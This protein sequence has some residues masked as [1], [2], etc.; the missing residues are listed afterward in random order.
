MPGNNGE[1]RAVVQGVEQNGK[2]GPY[3]WA[4]AGGIE[5]NITFSLLPENGWQENVWPE[6]G[7]VVLLDD[8]RERRLGWR[9]HQ[10]KLSRPQLAT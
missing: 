9:A 2:H 5:G 8:I 3:A 10:A 6:P 4:E 1:V 7:N